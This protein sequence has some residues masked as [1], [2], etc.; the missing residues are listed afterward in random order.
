M[1]ALII[2][3][4]IVAILVIVVISMYNNLV[5]TK[6]KAE[7]AEA[8]IDA[9]LTQRFDLIPNLVETVKGY[10]KHE[11]GTL[12]KVIQAR[13]AAMSATGVADRD[14][15]DN[16]LSGTLKSLFAL[17]ESYPELK[18]NQN[19]ISLQE[20]LSKIEKEL[21]N[22]RKYYNATAR[23]FNDRIMTFPSNIIASMFH[24]KKLDYVKAEEGA[25]V[26]P[27]VSF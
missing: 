2:V 16:I 11:E 5:K 7:E 23:T 8:A 25:K 13:N 12:E 21:L 20:E 26:A 17:S 19:F 1:S 18:A 14:A 24:F 6:N 10:A 3:L 9:H 27:K 4:L 15:K 22:A